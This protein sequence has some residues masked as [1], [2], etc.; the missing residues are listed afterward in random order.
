VRTN[1]PR[2]FHLAILWK[3]NRAYP[4]TIFFFEFAKILIRLGLTD[5]DRRPSRQ[6]LD[7][8]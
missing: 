3:M 6:N 5:S 4:P 7:S 2:E 1:T 8:K